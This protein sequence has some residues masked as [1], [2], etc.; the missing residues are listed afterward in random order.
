MIAI[1]VVG[2]RFA[3]SLTYFAL[4]PGGSWLLYDDCVY[5]AEGSYLL[6]LGF[7]PVTILLQPDRFE[8][9]CATA[10]GYHVAYYWWNLTAMYLFGEHYYAACFMNVLLTFVSGHY[11]GRTFS[12][13]GMPR[14]YCVAGQTFQL[15]HWDIVTW[16]S[17][18]NLKDL[19]VQALTIGSF[20]CVVGF[21]LER[22]VRYIAGFVLL[23][24]ILFWIRFYIPFLIL[25]S[26]IAWM[27]TQW[28]DKQKFLM[29]PAA[30]GGCYFLVP[31]LVANSEYL[32]PSTLLAG[33]V[34]FALTPQPWKI[35]DEYSFLFAS[36][37]LHW[38]F[39]LPTL[40]GI[41]HLWNSSKV[42]R[43]FLIYL[44]CIICA[45][46]I[47]DELLGPR[48]R[49]QVS[50]IFAWAQFHFHWHMLLARQCP[51]VAQ[52]PFPL[53]ERRLSAA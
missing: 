27:L 45:F 8:V 35:T 52:R 40:W 24:A 34:R 15:L 11:L 17:L 5:F 36:S 46:A 47:N 23:G 33:T 37:L 29:I 13:L 4:H 30:L 18:L 49:L 2:L 31:L 26:A 21:V 28:R 39:F 20:Y 9:L 44:A 12:L 3:I 1:V 42:V 19:L 41:W 25:A 7:D 43:V 51:T 48:H 53:R 10:G 50:F 6:R 22:R 38:L 16:S 14:S 32:D